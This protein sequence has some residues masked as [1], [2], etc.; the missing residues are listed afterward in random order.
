MGE[1]LRALPK[2]VYVL[3]QTWSLEF[4]FCG[5]PEIHMQ[6]SH[7][8]GSNAEAAGQWHEENEILLHLF[9]KA[10]AGDI[11]A[12][13]E[14]YNCTARWLLSVVRRLV[15]DG[16]AEDVLAEAYIQVWKTLDSY[17]A[18]KAPPRVWLAVIARSR[19]LDHL[20]REKRLGQAHDSPEMIS[21]MELHDRDGPEQ[22][23][24]R[25][26]EC[27]LVQLSLAAT[28]LSPDERTVL[29]L[30]YFRDSTQQEIS[31]LT[32]LPLGT[33][34]TIMVRARDKLKSYFEVAGASPRSPEAT[35]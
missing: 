4:T 6:H 20:R 16:Q 10:G 18:A 5:D 31:D 7:T 12:F 11:R 30:A 32:G 21:A 26:E 2:H 23:L 15:D 3:Q 8:R 28:Q 13:E 24:S 1:I 9:V 27:R 25:A 35:A 34:K 19:A 22:L 17:D 33:V 29:G 14:I